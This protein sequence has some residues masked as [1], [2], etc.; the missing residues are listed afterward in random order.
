LFG[1]NSFRIS[2]SPEL[3]PRD[4]EQRPAPRSMPAGTR[5]TMIATVVLVLLGVFVFNVPVVKRWVC[6]GL[7]DLLVSAGV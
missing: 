5:W 2:E 3:M 1:G 6:L 7:Y 4:G